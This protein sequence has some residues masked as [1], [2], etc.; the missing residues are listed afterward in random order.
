MERTEAYV[1]SRLVILD[2]NIGGM[3][4]SWYAS[5]QL[6]KELP[7]FDEVLEV[8]LDRAEGIPTPMSDPVQ[9]FV[10]GQGLLIRMGISRKKCDLY[11]GIRTQRRDFTGSRIVGNKYD[12]AQVGERGYE[13]AVANNIPA[14]LLDR[15]SSSDISAFV[16]RESSR[17]YLK[18][19]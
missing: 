7:A 3:P 1:K 18:K 11:V 12:T 13:L 8:V 2:R 9:W 19:Q 16:T 15:Y 4:N 6:R 14:L 10:T 5:I 17:V